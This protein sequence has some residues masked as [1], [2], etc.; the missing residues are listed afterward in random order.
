VT[1]NAVSKSSQADSLVGRIAQSQITA[2]AANGRTDLARMENS[3]VIVSVHIA[4]ESSSEVDAKRA[5]REVADRLRDALIAAVGRDQIR[6]AI[7]QARLAERNAEREKI[8]LTELD[9]QL[10][11]LALDLEP[12]GSRSVASRSPVPNFVDPRERGYFFLPIPVQID[13]IRSAQAHNR[14]AMHVASQ[15]EARQ[16]ARLAFFLRLD[17]RLESQDLAVGGEGAQVPELVDK[18]LDGF[19]AERA[20]R[21]PVGPDLVMDVEAWQEEL[22]EFYRATELVQPPVSST[23]SKAPMFAGAALA[24]LVLVL[25]AAVARDT[26]LRSRATR[27]PSTSHVAL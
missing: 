10:E 16:A 8:R 5:V 3:D 22:G 6:R 19:V 23:I 18:V 12:L 20:N 14:Q 7:S 1:E 4:F 15:I 11:R 21:D 2:I 24:A 27:G 17:Q 26:W 25:G 13:G 9:Q